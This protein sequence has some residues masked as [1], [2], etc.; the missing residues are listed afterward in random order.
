ML[1]TATEN[2]DSDKHKIEEFLSEIEAKSFEVQ[3]KLKALEIENT[4]LA[5][6]SN[7]YKQNLEKLNKEKKEILKKATGEAAE[8]LKGVNRKV[9]NVIKDLRETKAGAESIKSAKVLVNELKAKNK[10]LMKESVEIS[11]E[12]TN[13]IIGDF[14]GIKDSNT[15]GQIIDMDE[16]K[17][18]AI[19]QVGVM[20]ITADLSSLFHT[21][22][23][24]E[25]VTSSLLTGF[26][27]QQVGTRLDIRGQRALESEFEITKFI[28]EAYSS[29][30][31]RVEILHGK[32]TGA[33]K[34]TVQ[35]ILKQ[36]PSVS[37]FYFAPIEMGGDGIT[38]VELSKE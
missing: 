26:S 38:I 32:G 9:E 37:N 8:Y 10:E 20:K 17:N 1:N 15:V 29:G 23:Q 11:E 5:G 22:K 34:K 30:L 6:L 28:D 35:D 31:D 27:N 7:L 19:L 24:K 13:F 12:K 33:L 4:R 14:V 25:T 2:L 16:S 21:K 36:H 3:K 18:K